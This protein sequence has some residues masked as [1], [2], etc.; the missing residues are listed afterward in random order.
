MNAQKSWVNSSIAEP[1]KNSTALL[2]R[3][4]RLVMRRAMT[5]GLY[6]LSTSCSLIPYAIRSALRPEHVRSHRIVISLKATAQSTY[7]R[8]ERTYFFLF[9]LY[10]I[11]YPRFFFLSC[12]FKSH[13]I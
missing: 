4:F 6:S 10:P 13:L 12:F 11:L 7:G 3:W 5:V 2:H 1:L 9:S 8:M